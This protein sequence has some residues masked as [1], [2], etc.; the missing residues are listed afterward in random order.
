MFDYHHKLIQFKI[1]KWSP[2]Q[3]ATYSHFIQRCTIPLNS[4]N[5]LQKTIDLFLCWF[6][7]MASSSHWTYEVLKHKH[8]SSTL[9]ATTR[10]SSRFV[11]L[12]CTS[13]LQDQVRPN[14]AYRYS[15]RNK[16]QS[17][18]CVPPHSRAMKSILHCSSELPVWNPELHYSRFRLTGSGDQTI[19]IVCPGIFFFLKSDEEP[20]I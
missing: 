18:G 3:W 7:I 12:E 16:S 17:S 4:S 10:Q 15:W 5:N 2:V 13:T 20:Q 19:V 11:L 1:Q 9:F 8:G 6:H 14:M